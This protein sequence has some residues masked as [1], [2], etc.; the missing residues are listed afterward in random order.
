MPVAVRCSSQ[1]DRCTFLSCEE[2]VTKG[3]RD[4]TKFG[5]LP[6]LWKAWQLAASSSLELWGFPGLGGGGWFLQVPFTFWLPGIVAT[7]ALVLMNMVPRESLTSEEYYDDD[8]IV[9]PPPPPPQS[10]HAC[11]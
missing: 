3:G 7:V 11:W 9:S 10:E 4:P 6:S 8:A 5:F 2:A 1:L